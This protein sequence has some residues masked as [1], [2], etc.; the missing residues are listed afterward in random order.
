MVRYG[1]GSDVKKNGGEEGGGQKT[2]RGRMKKMLGMVSEVKRKRRRLRVRQMGSEKRKA[3]GGGQ[4]KRLVE[5][6]ER[7][8]K[9]RRRERR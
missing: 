4:G 6:E 9:G 1:E 5:G 7:M 3:G 2:C 8:V